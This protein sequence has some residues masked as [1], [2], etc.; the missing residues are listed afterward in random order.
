RRGVPAPGAARRGPGAPAAV[1]G[2]A[3]ARR[4]RPRA[5]TRPRGWRVT[6]RGRTVSRLSFSGYDRETREHEIGFQTV[7]HI[8]QRLD[9]AGIAP[10]DQADRLGEVGAQ[11]ADDAIERT[12]CRP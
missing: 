7:R 11:R 10:R 2:A 1:P 3:L 4:R 5:S 12:D 9:G 8:E 6:G